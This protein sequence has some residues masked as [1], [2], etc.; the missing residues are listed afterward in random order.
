MNLAGASHFCSPA[1]M[2]FGTVGK[3]TMFLSLHWSSVQRGFAGAGAATTEVFRVVWSCGMIHKEWTRIYSWW[4][5]KRGLCDVH[6]WMGETSDVPGVCRCCWCSIKPLYEQF[7]IL[8]GWRWQLTLL[9]WT[10]GWILGLRLPEH[11]GFT[12]PLA[13]GGA[14]LMLLALL[15][16]PASWCEIPSVRYP[17]PSYKSFSHL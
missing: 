3:V 13:S 11:L 12:S 7:L 9:F 6:T 2:H 8:Q 10:E 1:A 15:P 16:A 14:L 17:P 4:W 5:V